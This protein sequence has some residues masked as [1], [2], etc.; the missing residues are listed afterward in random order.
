[1]NDLNS[2]RQALSE[3]DKEMKVMEEELRRQNREYVALQEEVRKLMLNQTN[4]NTNQI[5]DLRKE[6]KDVTLAM[7][8]N[9]I[10]VTSQ[11]NYNKYYFL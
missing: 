10:Q 3:K 7:Q 4:Q 1:M 9:I 5:S 2:T 8:Q 6:L 11:Y